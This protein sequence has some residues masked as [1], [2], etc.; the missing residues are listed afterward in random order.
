MLVREK[1]SSLLYPCVSYAKKWSVMNKHPKQ[2]NLGAE[3]PYWRGS[4]STVDLIVLT[5][6]DQLLFK[7]TPNFPSL[8]KQPILMRGSTVLKLPLRQEFPAWGDPTFS[9]MELS[10][11]KS[12]MTCYRAVCNIW[13]QNCK[14]NINLVN[15]VRLNVVVSILVVSWSYPQILS[16]V[17][18]VC[19]GQTLAYNVP[20]SVTKK[21]GFKHWQ[22]KSIIFTFSSSLLKRP[23]NLNC[24]SLQSLSS[25]VSYFL[26]RMEPT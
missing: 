17:G 24:L 25:L 9:T 12:I 4:I 6:L 18:K 5:S 3:K 8:Q 7:L 22:V 13:Q 23:N 10:W 26:V 16:Q 21:K 14:C 2:S 20:S 11:A 19:Q 15:V 1:H